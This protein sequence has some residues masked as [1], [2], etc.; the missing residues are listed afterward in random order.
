MPMSVVFHPYI[1]MN[2]TGSFSSKY[3]FKFPGEQ[4]KPF[5]SFRADFTALRERKPTFLFT[6]KASGVMK[7]YIVYAVETAE[8]II[9]KIQISH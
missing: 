5:C 7:S 8:D 1:W 6:K 4:N 3:A 2:Q 9:H